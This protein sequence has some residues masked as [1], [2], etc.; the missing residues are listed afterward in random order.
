MKK[1]FTL[2]E[3]L[4]YVGILSMIVLVVSSLFLWISRSSAKAKATR[5]ALNN[6]R[7]AVEIMTHEIREAN[8][9]YTPTSAFS[10]STGQLSLETIKYLPEG[11]NRSYIDF[12]I[13]EKRLC[14]KKE[15]QDPIALTSGKVEIKSLEFSQVAT[16]STIPSVQ[17]SLK[18]D[19]GTP[20]TQPS[21]QASINTTSTVSLRLY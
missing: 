2:T 19:Y 16:T 20:D 13:C 21:Y 6:S 4:V 1:G 3:I 17:I 12:Y 5:E 14:L 18:I 7:R 11:E 9:I 10:I 15:G 8:S